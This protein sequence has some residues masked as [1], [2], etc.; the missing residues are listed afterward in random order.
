MLI[1]ADGRIS[2]TIGGGKFESLVVADASVALR[3]RAPLL[4]TYPLHEAD[5]D[6]FGAICGGEATVFIEPQNQN[7]ALFL[8]GGG[9]CSRAIAK[10]AL[11]C[12][13]H[14]TVIEDR[15]ELLSD[16][17]VAA[18]RINTPAPSFITTRQWQPTDA[19]LL[20]SRNH[21]LDQQALA[22]SMRVTG[23]PYLGM[24]GSQRKVHLVFDAL[25]SAGVPDEQLKAVY[26]PL[27]LDIGA[28][29]PTEI[30]ISALAELLAVLRRRAGTHLALARAN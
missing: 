6:S 30:A 13:M 25:R 22:A 23:I 8:V 1:Y 7:V 10:L 17:P 26:A 18:H 20:V 9:H 2:G 5:P 27:G 14:V 29:S 12:G 16:F 24:I 28:D 19:L 11:D 21:E 3:D 4:K 15:E